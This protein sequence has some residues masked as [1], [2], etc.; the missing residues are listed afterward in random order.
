MNDDR[1]DGSENPSLG[2]AVRRW[3]KLDDEIKEITAREIDSRKNEI[4]EIK[5]KLSKE[6]ED[7]DSKGIKVEGAGSATFRDEFYGKIA[8]DEDG[9]PFP[10]EVVER[11]LDEIGAVGVVEKKVNFKNLTALVRAIIDEGRPMPPSLTFSTKRDLRLY[12]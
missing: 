10:I 8:D 5:E 1:L 9:N 3:R 6:L 7:A 12:R 11:E 4:A 2:E